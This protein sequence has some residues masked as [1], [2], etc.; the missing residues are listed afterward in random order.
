MSTV[1]LDLIRGNF[2][3]AV[4]DF[5]TWWD[6]VPAW[7][8]NFLTKIT[9]DEGAIL[10]SLVSTAVTDVQSGGV[11]TASFVAAG[12][13]VLAKLEAQNISTFNMQYVMAAINAAAADAGITKPQA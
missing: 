6:N 11:T 8:K 1:F 2:S 7:A 5:N 13:D 9:G 3:Q 12:K 4:T 10:E